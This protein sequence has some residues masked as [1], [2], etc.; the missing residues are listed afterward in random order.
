VE[1]RETTRLY[2]LA[3]EGSAEAL[4]QL[5]RRC[6]AKLLPLIRLRLGPV[7]RNELESRDIL[8]AVLVKFFQD[9]DRIREPEAV[10]AWLSRVAQNEIRDR[11]DYQHRQRRDAALAVP[12]DEALEVPA[13]LRHA[14][15]QV[16]VNEETDRLER[17]LESLPESQREAIILRKFEELTFPEMAVR[18][19]RSE[20]ACR[21]L[22]ARAMTALTVAWQAGHS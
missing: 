20:D 8:Q 7:R 14:L 9:L 15:S 17:A 21:M 22:F 3:R 16:I 19:G 13:P 5:C 6:A 1:L 10:M 18:L 2:G 12:I 4:D 11:L